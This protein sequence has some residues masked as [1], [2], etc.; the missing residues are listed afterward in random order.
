MNIL[1][2]VKIQLNSPNIVLLEKVQSLW[3]GYGQIIRCKDT[4]THQHYIVKAISPKKVNKHPRGWNTSVSHQRKIKSY[5]VEAN[6]YQ[7][8]APLT[9]ARN[10]VPKLIHS[11]I[12]NSYTLLIMEDLNQAGYKV[13]QQVANKQSLFTAIKWLAYFHA[14]F[15]QSTVSDTHA[16][17]LWPIGSYWHLATRQDEWA[18]MPESSYKTHAST[19]DNTLN[20]AKYQTLVHGDAKFANLCFTP[21]FTSVAAVDFQYVGMGSGVK[22]LAYLAGGCLSDKALFEYDETIVKQYLV[23]LKQALEHYQSSIDFNEL[24]KEVT[25]L[26]PIAWADFYRFLLGWNPDS[27]KIGGYMKAKAEQGLSLIGGFNA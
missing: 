3:S 13:H 26:Y 8:F 24:A 9:D 14:R 21:N 2:D 19:I 10:K 18:A 16:S 12:N 7:H 23:Q 5:Q 1:D 17:M 4:V 27:V 20:R 22:D 11:Y 6:F 25:K 15:M